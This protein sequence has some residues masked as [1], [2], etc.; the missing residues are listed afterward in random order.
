MVLM[1]QDE[2]PPSRLFTNVAPN[3][4]GEL[5]RV[6]ASEASC[7]AL[8]AGTMIGAG[9]LAL[10]DVT[11]PAGFVPS[12]AALTAVWAYMVASALLLTGRCASQ[13]AHLSCAS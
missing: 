3:D 2:W 5:K 1:T 11:A 10:P 13:A 6:K 7:A 8:I 9:V 12:S 4:K